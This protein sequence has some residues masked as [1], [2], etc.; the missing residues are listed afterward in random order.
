MPWT[1][2]PAPVDDGR[3]PTL[4]SPKAPV[5]AL[6]LVSSLPNGGAPWQQAYDPAGHLGIST[7]LAGL[8]LIVLLLGLAV[9][10]MKA[11]RC[12][13]LAAAVCLA[14]AV[15]LFHMPAHLALLAAAYGAAYGAFPIFWIIFPVIFL[16]ELTVKA[17]RFSLLHGCITGITQ[18]SR[19]QLLVVAFALGAFFEGAAGFGTPVAV[20]GT[21]LIGFG[22][23]PLRAAALA[24]LANTA[25]VAF[26]GLGIPV[27]ALAGITGLEL[28][29]LTALVATLLTPFCVLVPF[30]LIWAFA[31][32]TA[33]VEVWPAIVVAGVSFGATQ[34]FIARVHGPWLVD[35]TASAVAIVCLLVLFRFW[36]PRRILDAEGNVMPADAS[37]CAAPS[38]H[39]VLRALLPWAILT[40]GVTLWGT[41]AFTHAL[42]AFSTFNLHVRGLDQAVLRVP[43]AVPRP[44]A[45]PA[46]FTLNLLSATGTGIFLSAIVAAFA[47]GLRAGETLRVLR[48]TMRLTIFSLITIAALMSIGFVSR[49][50]GLDATLGLALAAT[51][52]FYPFFGTFIG[53]LGTA[54]TGSD[55][56][57]NVL[58]G[59]LQTLTAQQLG[60]SPFLMAAANSAGGVMAKMVSPQN[61][62]VATTATG[63]YGKEGS[64]VRFVLLPSLALATLVG[65]VVTF[66]AR[67]PEA[68]RTLM[69]H[70][71]V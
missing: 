13:L 1:A 65:L 69:G 29:H 58:F 6:L 10:R 26:G 70:F 21:L 56:S 23:P 51:G 38:R 52:A 19:L 49:Y 40:A 17:G 28:H 43:P 22:F 27:V 45:E 44:A 2:R 53:W 62:V 46:V 67:C 32:F 48:A 34:L 47:M 20:C 14:V 57:S 35:I 42:N 8:P 30:W 63:T 24:L 18:D 3:H 4:R 64:V 68:A 55:T 25:P 36:Q 11:H 39:N 12:A 37:A 54:S 9:F 31:G 41:P 59:S 15:G 66:F 71:G 7:L 16:Y 50:C 33:M 60:L 5:I 61:V